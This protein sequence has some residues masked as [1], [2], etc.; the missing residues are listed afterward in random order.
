[1]NIRRLNYF[2]VLA[3]TGN[4]RRAGE[5]LGVSPPALSKA[6]QV[7]E[8]EMDTKLWLREGKRMT[9]TDV[10][11]RLL[12][13]IPAF[14]E[15]FES[16][17]EN[18]D[19]RQGAKRAI[20]LGTFEVF[21]TYF[22]TFLDKLKWDDRSLELH[23]LLP[24]E[25]E[26]YVESGE[27]D[28]GISYMPISNA[29]LDFLKITS[30]EMGVFARKGS[31][32]GIA[33]KDLPFVVPA[34][35]LQGVPTRMRGLDGWPDDAYRRHV[36]HKVTLMESALELCRQGRVAGYFPAFVA[37]EHNARVKS[38]FQ[39]ERKKSPYSD[40]VCKVDVFLVKRKSDEES[41]V[42]KQLAKAVRLVCT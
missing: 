27:L 9:L 21:S 31:F 20:R 40:R 41:E 37:R 42:A 38:E 15:E 35:P 5:L 26:R 14:L 16:L 4:L 32:S 36:T 25:V 22:L 8:E 12:K 3:N 18:V 19:P 7:L 24:G 34:T 39:L 29:N 30:I 28:F 2:Q 1:M 11:K 13:R 17:K 10:G 33:Q 6:M 23:E